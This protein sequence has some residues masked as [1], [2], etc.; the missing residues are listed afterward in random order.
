MQID[1]AAEL[2]ERGDSLQYF[3]DAVL[4]HAANLLVRSGFPNFALGRRVSHHFLYLVVH[5]DDLD[6]RDAAFVAEPATFLTALGQP[7]R[8]AIS[9]ELIRMR[10]VAQERLYELFIFRTQRLRHAA[11]GAE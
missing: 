9:G 10:D 7:H 4:P 6:D 1:D 3:H 11:D 2:F 5:E 8:V